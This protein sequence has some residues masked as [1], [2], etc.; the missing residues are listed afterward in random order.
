M[1][2]IRRLLKWLHILVKKNIDITDLQNAW[3]I[4]FYNTT[5]EEI[6]TPDMDD[7]EFFLSHRVPLWAHDLWRG[8]MYWKLYHMQVQWYA[9]RRFP[10]FSR[11]SMPMKYIK[12]RS[13]GVYLNA[14]PTIKEQ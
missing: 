3:L 2:T 11:Y 4:P 7:R 6:Y 12:R 14:A 10:F 13:W 5:V 9:E 8:W 1:E